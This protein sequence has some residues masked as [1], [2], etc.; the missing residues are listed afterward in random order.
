MQALPVS[1]LQFRQLPT[2]HDISELIG[3]N[4]GGGGAL[5][6]KNPQKL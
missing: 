3:V 1:D 5:G 6:A 2:V 4:T